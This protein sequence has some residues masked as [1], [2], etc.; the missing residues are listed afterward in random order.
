MELDFQSRGD[1]DLEA[2]CCIVGAGAVGLALAHE[3]LGSGRRLVLVESGGWEPGEQT[4]EL[5]AG[6]SG[7]GNPVDLRGSRSRAFGGT[8]RLWAGQC[9]RLDAED[10]DRRPWVPDS[11]WPLSAGEVE[12][13]YRDAERLLD[14]EGAVYDDRNWSPHG[15][16]PPDLAP[17]LLR[18]RFTVY[19]RRVDLGKLLRRRFGK[20]RDLR[21]VVN[22][23]ASRVLTDASGMHATGV[24]VRSLA[25]GRGSVRAGTVV[26]CAGGIE[27]P[28]LLLLSRDLRMPREAIG[29]YFQEH[30]NAMA[31]TIHTDDHA[32]LQD[33]YALLYRR[34]RRYFP[35]LCL[36]FA[37]QR[38]R[39]VLNCTSALV[40]EHEGGAAALKEA[41]RGVRDRRPARTVARAGAEAIGDLRGLGRAAR[42]R[43]VRGLSPDAAPSRILLQ[44]FSEQAPN[45][46]SRVTLADR[47]DALGL[48]RARVEWRLGELE[49][50]TVA[51]MASA[52]ARELERLRLGTVRLA[53]WVEDGSDDTAA[54]HDGFHHM[55]TTRM[56][57]DPRRGVVDRDLRVHGVE[58]LYVAGTSAFPTSG[59][60]NPTLTAMALGIRLGRHLERTG[61]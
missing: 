2:D 57:D 26:L 61:P 16:E 25:G 11:G 17:D 58:G 5:N 37:E 36:S 14:I 53:A 28:R 27:N 23:T 38:R 47:P 51:T 22:A 18:H 46:E 9:V 33:R 41:V 59:W 4:G 30:P 34:G 7:G 40:F 56:A 35:R 8:T 3:L 49:R 29:R 42:R 54:L 44:V 10:F 48:P 13:Y 60:A 6:I 20:A 50:R 32:Y 52:V 19:P 12:P 15:V 45:P 21:V 31:A 43:F 55:G 1:L 39:E 24:E